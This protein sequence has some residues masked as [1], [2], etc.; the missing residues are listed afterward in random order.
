[1]LT[2]NFGSVVKHQTLRLKEI[3]SIIGNYNAP[4]ME[5]F[6]SFFNLSPETLLRD[7]LLNR[8]PL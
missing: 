5:D 2:S 3:F 4:P 6:L 1:M 8:P 7:H